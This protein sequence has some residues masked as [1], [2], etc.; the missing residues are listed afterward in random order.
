MSTRK[1]FLSAVGRLVAG[2]LYK[3]NTTDAEGNPL[4]IKNGPNAGQDRSEVYFALAIPKGAERHW[5]ETPW[6]QIIWGVGHGSFPNGAAQSPA[7]SWKITDGDSTVANTKGKRPCDREGY[8]GHWVL[9]YSSG[10]KP[11]IVTADGSQPILEDDAV[12]TGYYVQVYGYAD[13]NGSSQRPGVYLNHTAVAFAGYGPEIVTGPDLTNV[14]FGQGTAL[15]VGASAV[16]LGAMQAPASMPAAPGA[17]VM[18]PVPGAPVMPPVP[19]APAMPPVPGAPVA[20][21]LPVVPNHAFVAATGA[22]PGA[23]A[24]P[25][26]PLTPDQRL[27]AA[28][29]GA[30]YADLVGAGWTDALLIQH[31]LMTQ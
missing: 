23:P 9:N 3:V 24:M 5:A 30:S 27:T 2:S 11:K 26:A 1:D 7:F 16:P 20:A 28:A 13:G 15:P 17:P 10:F 31:G 12:K 29:N 22:V 18:P 4:K 6:G 25:A 14:G 21:P 8:K 19:G